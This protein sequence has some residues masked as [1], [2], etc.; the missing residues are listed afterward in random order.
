MRDIIRQ[1]RDSVIQIATPYGTGTGFLYP[2]Q[3]LIITNH[4][5]VS[6]SRDVTIAGNNMP[7]TVSQVVYNDPM[8]DLAF[9]RVPEHYDL[10]SLKLGSMENLSEGDEI[11]AIGHPFGLKY[12]AT[13]GI[14]S[15]L[16]RQWNGMEYIQI[17]AAIN[18]GNSG[19]PLINQDGEVIGVNTFI[20]RDGNSLGFA[21]PV[22]KLRESLDDFNARHG[23]Q[24]IRCNS[25]SNIITIDSIQNGY[26]PECGNKLNA[27]DYEGKEYLPGSMALK[28]EAALEKAGYNVQL[29][30]SGPNLWNIEKGS[31]RIRVQYLPNTKFIYADAVLGYLPKQNLAR[32]YEFMLRKD[33]ELETAVLSI[34]GREVV[35]SNVAYED[36]FNAEQAAEAYGHLFETADQLDSLLS[37]EYGLV[38]AEDED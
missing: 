10:P 12:T 15:K 37:R 8:Y 33:A 19:G 31:A 17:D 1:F 26:C 30:R 18:P 24:A 28:I 14:I 34:N 13:Q 21:L 25:C 9:I 23:H 7:K 36:D 32:L 5:V 4:H 27:E 20:I 29:A 35:V 11:V 2:E 38:L 6:G 22:D 3:R 16:R